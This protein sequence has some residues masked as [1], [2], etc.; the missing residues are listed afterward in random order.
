MTCWPKNRCDD[1]HWPKNRR[2]DGSYFLYN[3]ANLDQPIEDIDPYDKSLSSWSKS[4]NLSVQ[5]EVTVVCG[6]VGNLGEK[7]ISVTLFPL[8]G[9]LFDHEAI[10]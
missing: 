2:D 7:S 3:Q 8:S 6:E 4:A 9:E 5:Q 1:D 10:C